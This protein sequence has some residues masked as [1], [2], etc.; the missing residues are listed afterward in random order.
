MRRR[1][2]RR[3]S[4]A[5]AYLAA[6]TNLLDLMKGGALR[7]DRLVD[8]TRLPGLDRIERLADGGVRIGAMVRNADLAHDA[9]FRPR[10]SGRRGSAALGRLRAAPQRRDRRRQPDAADALQLLLRRG[11][12]LQPARTRRRLR[13]AARREPPA[14]GARLERALH[15]DPS[16]GFL[17]CRSS[18]STPSSRSKARRAGAR[19]RSKTFTVCPATR[20][21]AKRR[22]SRAT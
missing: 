19:L 20:R 14:C 1:S 12:R 5:A 15:R 18:R 11:E 7:P 13:R 17:P 10:L 9:R 2:P 8:V 16:V 22:S 6:G 4:R 3:R 21:S